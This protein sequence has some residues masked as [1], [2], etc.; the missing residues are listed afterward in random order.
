MKKSL[1]SRLGPLGAGVMVE[2]SQKFTEKEIYEEMLRQQESRRI[3]NEEKE[4]RKLKKAMRKKEKLEK[5][6][7]KHKKEN[8]KSRKAA[9]NDDSDFSESEML[10]SHL[11]LDTRISVRWFVLLCPSPPLD[12]ETGW[13]GEL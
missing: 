9:A 4:I 1:S 8:K 10:V 13:T 6:L 5:K 7:K 2:N 3:A 11:I 12:S